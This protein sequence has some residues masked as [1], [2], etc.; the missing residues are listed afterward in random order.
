MK[1]WKFY[2]HFYFYSIFFLNTRLKLKK[3]LIKRNKHKK[4]ISEVSSFET[5]RQKYTPLLK[6]EKK[7]E[8]K[9]NKK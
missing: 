9:T 1:K 7:K 6:E 4:A 2:K 8:Q 3:Y 5:Y